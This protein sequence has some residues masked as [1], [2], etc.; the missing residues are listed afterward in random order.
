MEPEKGGQ[1]HEAHK[2]RRSREPPAPHTPTD[3]TLH[4]SHGLRER[5]RGRSDPSPPKVIR[6]AGRRPTRSGIKVGLEESTGARSLRHGWRAARVAGLQKAGRV[7]RRGGVRRRAL[8][9]LEGARGSAVR[10][11]RQPRSAGGRPARRAGRRRLQPGGAVPRA[12]GARLHGGRPAGDAGPSVHRGVVGRVDAGARQGAHQE[13]VRLPGD[14]DPALHGL[15]P[16]GADAAAE[17][18]ALPADRQAAR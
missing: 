9:A 8:P 12:V 4:H 7:D 16:E 3:T 18:P 6:S 13:G 11:S 5:E 1:A 2:G 17:R 14:P 15:P 10:F